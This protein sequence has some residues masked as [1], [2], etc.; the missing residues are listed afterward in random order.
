MATL[1][2]KLFIVGWTVLI[3][4]II[5]NGMAAILGLK[6]WYDLIALLNEHGIKAFSFLSFFDFLW[7]LVVYPLLLGGAAVLIFR[8]LKTF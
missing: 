7:L 8:F 2:W 4:A 1:F 6:S 5:A 3:A